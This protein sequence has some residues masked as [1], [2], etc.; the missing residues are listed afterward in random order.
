MFTFIAIVCHFSVDWEIMLFEKPVITNKA[1][2]CLHIL[3]SYQCL[4]HLQIWHSGLR[5]MIQA[6]STNKCAFLYRQP[7]VRVM[8]TGLS[9]VWGRCGTTG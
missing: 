4:W 1:S 9:V 6:G 2:V 8:G 3:C 5:H 7:H